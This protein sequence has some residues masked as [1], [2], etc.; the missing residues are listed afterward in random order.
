MMF[1]SLSPARYL[2][3]KSILSPVNIAAPIFLCWMLACYIFNPFTVNLFVPMYLKSIFYKQ[4][5]NGCFLYSIWKSCLFIRIFN[6][7]KFGAVIEIVDF[8]PAILL[9][10]F[11]VSD[12]LGFFVCLFLLSYLLIKYFL[13]FCLSSSVGFLLSSQFMHFYNG[14]SRG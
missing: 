14:C 4:Y 5:I 10:I 3:L 6:Q 12:H 11:F 7:H 13:I 1:L 8:T 2:I 9:F